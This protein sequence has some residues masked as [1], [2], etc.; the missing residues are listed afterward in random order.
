MNQ[1]FQCEDRRCVIYNKPII[2]Y[3]PIISVLK[4]EMCHINQDF[5]INLSLQCEDRICVIYNKP[6]ISVLRQEMCHINQDFHI[7]L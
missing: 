1:S 5:H 2:S 4:Q 7:N 6:I 3:K